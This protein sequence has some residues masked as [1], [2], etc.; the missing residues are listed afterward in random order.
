MVMNPGRRVGEKPASDVMD[1]G[2]RRNMEQG[3]AFLICLLTTGLPAL[4]YVPIV[5]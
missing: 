3:A 1:M 2:W 5:P 4:C